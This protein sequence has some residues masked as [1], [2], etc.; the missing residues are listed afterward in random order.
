MGAHPKSS[1]YLGADYV[2]VAPVGAL[3]FY[4][5]PG[6]RKQVEEAL[7]G[8]GTARLL[9]CDLSGV[10]FMDSTALGELVRARRKSLDAGARFCVVGASVTCKRVLH[11]TQLDTVIPGFA[12]IPEA[13]FALGG[14]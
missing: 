6:F 8:R 11:W 4:S 10:D 3:D 12:T 1:T 2:V 5:S 9:C 13:I 14:A 7:D